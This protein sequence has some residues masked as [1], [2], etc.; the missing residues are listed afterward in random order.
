MLGT[1]LRVNKLKHKIQNYVAYC[2]LLLLTKLIIEI[3]TLKL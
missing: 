3:C 1:L 2:L